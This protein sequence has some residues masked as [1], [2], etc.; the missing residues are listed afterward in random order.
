MDK[1]KKRDIIYHF[2]N[3]S[4]F[5]QSNV[6]IIHINL[7]YAALLDVVVRGKFDTEGIKSACFLFLCRSIAAFET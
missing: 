5:D 3:H 7:P 6:N 4:E 1:I 2:Q